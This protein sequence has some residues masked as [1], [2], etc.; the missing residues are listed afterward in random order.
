MW[1]ITLPT[2]NNLSTVKHTAGGVTLHQSI[3]WVRF[4]P[5]CPDVL[6]NVS[7]LMRVKV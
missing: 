1:S 6:V 5:N 4:D 3:F 7:C 2:E